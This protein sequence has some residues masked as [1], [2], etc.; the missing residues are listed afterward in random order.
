MYNFIKRCIDIS[1]SL[2]ALIILCPIYLLVALLVA[3]KLGRP[4]HFKQPRP[5]LNGKVFMMTKFRTMH[6]ATDSQ[7]QPLPDRQRLNSF[8]LKLRRSSLDELPGL[9]AVLKGDMSL[10]GPR[11]LLV[12]YLPLYSNEQAQR[13]NVKPGLTGWAQ[14]NG[15]NAISWQ[16]KF[17]L[18]LWYVN[19]QS[20]WL[21]LKILLMTIH[22]VCSQA[23]INSQ[24]E[25]S[26]SKFTGQP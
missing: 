25:A 11:P 5:G 18:D 17:Q 23:D 9:F 21:D 6:D 19:N 16:E 4:V 10:V 20:L 1:V 8:G 12:E 14:V 3:K 13:H 24:G 22:K 7:G 15:R 26:M 2:L